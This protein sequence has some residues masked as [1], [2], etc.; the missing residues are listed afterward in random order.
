MDMQLVTDVL[1][2][3]SMVQVRDDWVRM[4]G[5]ENFV[6]PDAPPSRLQN[7]YSLAHIGNYHQ[8]DPLASG[9]PEYVDEAVEQNDDATRKSNLPNEHE[10]ANIEG[11]GDL[12]AEDDDEEEVVFVMGQEAGW[13]PEH[14]PHHVH[15]SD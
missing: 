15:S 14:V 12:E 11:D 7:G 8:N 6:L 10:D 2:L 5:W 9:K 4:G 13:S 3:S 1:T